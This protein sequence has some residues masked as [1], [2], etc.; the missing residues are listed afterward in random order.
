MRRHRSRSRPRNCCAAHSGNAIPAHLVRAP[1][2]LSRARP[3]G[4]N[5][6]WE[7]RQL[8]MLDSTAIFALL[9]ALGAVVAARLGIGHLVAT[10]WGRRSLVLVAALLPVAATT[11]ALRA[12]VKESSQTRFCLSCHEMRDYGKSLFV[13]DRKSLPAVHYQNRLIDR[14]TACYSCH[15]DY[16][17]FG[18]VK[19]KVNGLKHVWVHYLRKVP[20][21]IE[22]YQPYAN[23]NCLHCHEDA[24]R[25]V[26]AAPHQPVIDRVRAGELKCMGCHNVDHDLKAVGARHFWQAQ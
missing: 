10:R 16:A 4:T 5:L 3:S 21:K 24:R 15:T 26:E 7:A 9:I 2:P 23:A 6:E 8:A 19:A 22:L 11:G 12:G 1:G 17:L 25:F 13:D 14:D 20:D 18:D